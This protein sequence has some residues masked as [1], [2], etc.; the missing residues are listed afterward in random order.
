MGNENF[1]KWKGNRG[2]GDFQI[3]IWYHFQTIFLFNISSEHNPRQH[4]KWNIHPTAYNRENVN[5]KIQSY[6]LQIIFVGKIKKVLWL[7]SGRA[8]VPSWY[9]LHLLFHLKSEKKTI[10]LVKFKTWHD[11]YLPFLQVFP[12]F[13]C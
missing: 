13:H 9:F 1:E 6:G 3:I 8:E 7:L 2:G 5:C 12:H 4:L 11:K 10:Y